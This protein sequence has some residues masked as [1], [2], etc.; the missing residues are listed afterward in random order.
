MNLA[1]DERRLLRLPVRGRT[2]AGPRE[3]GLASSVSRTERP[4]D[5][6]RGARAEFVLQFADLLGVG[7]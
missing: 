4:R 2:G 6:E 1:F 7:G 5:G 3:K